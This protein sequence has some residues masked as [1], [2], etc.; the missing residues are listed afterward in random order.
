MRSPAGGLSRSTSTKFSIQLSARSSGSAPVAFLWDFRS[1]GLWRFGGPL[2]FRPQST[3]TLRANTDFSVN[4]LPAAGGKRTTATAHAQSRSQTSPTCVHALVHALVPRSR[5]SR[6][7]GGRGI[8]HRLFRP[9]RRT[10][11]CRTCPCAA[12]ISS[13]PCPSRCWLLCRTQ[14]HHLV[15]HVRRL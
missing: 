8:A 2:P 1:P 10:A 11:N 12:L 5:V 6:R 3:P 14:C 4:R 15:F 13:R 7:R 9:Q